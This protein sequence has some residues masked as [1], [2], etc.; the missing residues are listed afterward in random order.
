MQLDL[1]SHGSGVSGERGEVMGNLKSTAQ[2]VDFPVF[3]SRK[4]CL[5]FKRDIVLVELLQGEWNHK[6]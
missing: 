3:T 4:L 5:T 1:H 2:C 6:A